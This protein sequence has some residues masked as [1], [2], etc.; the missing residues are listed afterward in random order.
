[1]LDLLKRWWSSSIPAPVILDHVP[2]G[3]GSDHRKKLKAAARKYGRPF[4]C[5]AHGI[6]HEV[7]PSRQQQKTPRPSES[8]IELRK[9]TGRKG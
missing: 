3:E 2:V 9:V 4:K 6:P 7:L 5:G 8:V 1:M